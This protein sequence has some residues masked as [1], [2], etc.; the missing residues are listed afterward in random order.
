MN[1]GTR[2][3]LMT[4]AAGLFGYMHP[5]S[6]MPPG[7]QYRKR[8]MGGP[9]GMPKGIGPGAPMPGV[10]LPPVGPQGPQGPGPA[11]DVGAYPGG[12]YDD[13]QDM[14]RD[15]LYGMGGGMQQGMQPPM[16]MAQGGVVSQPTTAIL[17]ESG[18]EMVV[19]LGGA[20]GARVGPMNAMQ[21]PQMNYQR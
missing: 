7:M 9:V 8:P 10:P 1:E 3:G 12:P 20:P 15:P 6:P 17:G 18:P 2:Q 5:G 19:P 21:R 13:P 4:G 16:T 14:G 11:P